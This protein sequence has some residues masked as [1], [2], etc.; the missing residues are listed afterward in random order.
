MNKIILSKAFNVG[1]IIM[2]GSVL[3]VSIPILITSHV[4][5]KKENP[6]LKGSELEI[7][8]D[9]LVTCAAS[10]MMLLA[11]KAI[12]DSIQNLKKK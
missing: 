6:D 1:S 2:G 11:T 10:T 9:L 4:K 12:C 8:D 3:L 5:Y 7:R